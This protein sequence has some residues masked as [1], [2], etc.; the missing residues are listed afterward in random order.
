MGDNAQDVPAL[1]E[2]EQVKGLPIDPNIIL[3]NEDI[4]L[5][6]TVY[7][8]T[9]QFRL[10]SAWN[11]EF[12][13]LH[14]GTT[15]KLTNLTYEQSYLY[16]KEQAK[17]GQSANILMLDNNWISEFAA[18]GY[19]SYRANEF[20]PNDIGPTFN[21]A[22]AQVEWNGYTW[23]VPHS[24]DPYIIV[25]NPS[26]VKKEEESKL[27]ESLDDWL[28]LHD[29]L[30]L[31]DPTY[32]GIHVDSSDEQSFVSL[33][34][35][36]RGNWSKELDR[37]YTL[38]TDK[39]IELLQKLMETDPI[40]NKDGLTKPLLHM[41]PLSPSESWDRFANNQFAAM[42]VP[43]SEW[44]ARKEGGEAIAVSLL[45][46]NADDTGLWLSGTSYAVSSQTIH[47]EM[48]YSWIAWMTNLTHQI[49]TLGVA[50]KLPANLTT[51]DSNSLLNLPQSELLAKAV[52]VGRAWSK[53]PQ[54]SI[55]MN[56]LQQ[57]IGDIDMNS[58]S[59]KDWNVQLQQ[60]WK[61]I[62]ATP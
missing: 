53:D 25:W 50:Y 5:T 27:P 47:Q 44:M 33:I 29:S 19:L 59:I 17:A 48:A 4:E 18:R 46:G 32:E 35:A 1:Q 21:Q 23:A 38:D 24:V 57:A 3:S 52:E 61:Q 58:S 40:D 28:I 6:A 7:M 12:E 30:L 8:D 60:S 10:L 51:L 45:G 9:E 55:K 41:Q 15:I 13:Q 31:N 11:D 22:L 43:L 16:S 34:W 2:S 26:L 36:F 49:Q 20:T 37:M 14:P 54:L 42:V 39:D 62:N 56:V